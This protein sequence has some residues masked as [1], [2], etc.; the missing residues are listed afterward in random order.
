[1]SAILDAERLAGKPGPIDV[2]TPVP[3]DRGDPP[4]LRVFASKPRTLAEILADPELSD[5]AKRVAQ[6]LDG[7][8]RAF[9]KWWAWPKVSTIADALGWKAEHGA[10]KRVERAFHE[11]TESGDVG[12]CNVRE[13]LEWLDVEGPTSGIAEPAGL[14]RHLRQN[15]KVCILGWKVGEARQGL[16][17]PPQCDTSVPDGP[18]PDSCQ[19]PQGVAY[20]GTEVSQGNETLVSHPSLNV[21]SLNVESEQT[22]DGLA[23]ATPEE[24]PS[25]IGAD[26]PIWTPHELAAKVVV[27]LH[28]SGN[29]PK[30][31]VVSEDGR[32]GIQ[33]MRYPSALAPEPEVLAEM[34]RLREAVMAYLEGVPDPWK[35]S[36]RSQSS[37]GAS[38]AIDSPVLAMIKALPSSGV[39]RDD[40]AVG[41]AIAAAI[42]DE[43]PESIETFTGY[44]RDVRR[45]Y[46]S[47]ASLTKAFQAALSK[48]S[49]KPGA[50]L[51]NRVQRWKERNPS[52]SEGRACSPAET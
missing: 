16:P 21:R 8:C 44:A 47:T 12:R 26:R 27:K 49:K 30:V 17:K 20:I 10:R 51:V 38:P 37:G 39:P 11:L 45:G 25:T 3:T 2:R 42:A 19:T 41:R 23:F 4:S 15:Q 36:S 32:K 7:R 5:R 40:Q 46:L 52:W 34:I 13:L 28:A 22:S 50:V 6:Y 29:L 35:S 9:A 24:E 14:P 1:V 43:K 48:G 33:L 31:V 18:T